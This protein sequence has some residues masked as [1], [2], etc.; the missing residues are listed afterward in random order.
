M[1]PFHYYAEYRVLVCK[2]CQYAVQPA[3]IATHLRSKQHKLPRSQGEEI[4]GKYKNVQLADPRREQVIPTTVVMPIEHLPI[5]RDGLA[6]KHCKFIGRSRD[7]MLRHQR[8]VHGMKIG[9]GRHTDQVEWTTVW[10]Q[11]FFT[12][13]GRCFFQVQNTYRPANSEV[14]P[15]LLQLIHQQLD[16][17]ERKE[18]EKRRI[19]RDSDEATE[20]SPWLERTEWIHHLAGQDKS[21]MAKLV[22]P[23]E[24]EE[25]ELQEVE[26]S[27]V[28]LVKKAQC[29]ISNKQ[30]SI[31][32]LHRLKS[33]HAGQDMERPFEVDMQKKTM[34]RYW[35]VWQ[36][37]LAYVLRTADTESRLYQLTSRQREDIQSVKS[38]VKQLQQEESEEK[39]EELQED[40][41][42]CCLRLCIALLH[43]KLNR[44]YDSAIVS[45]LAVMGLDPIH[46]GELYRFKSPAQYTP[47]LSG[48]IKVAQMLTLQYCY[49]QE[50][51]GEIISCRELFEQLHPQFLTV[52]TSTPMDWVLRLRLYGRKINNRM[53]AQGCINWVGET[54]IYEDIELS[55][56]DFRRLIHKLVEETRDIL[57][58]ELLF[59][60]SMGELP[61]YNWMELRDNA[62][63]DDPEWNF[64]K[65][66][67]NGMLGYERWLLDKILQ[68][69]ELQTRFVHTTG[70]WRQREVNSWFDKIS[71]FLEKLLVLIHMTGRQPA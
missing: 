38:I 3:Y 1:D 54:V 5:Y 48:F 22:Q 9:R 51:D 20:I 69:E 62:A 53:T 6:C 67:K 70:E 26:K 14:R 44:Q 66:G 13:V 65:D 7:W 68:S 8:E 41:D 57:L 2:S 61:V 24:K 16:E 59:V 19:I 63:K 34:E 39:V 17:K 42:I 56:A 10:C 40:L 58:H 45:G 15:T 36:Q 28:R 12:G 60:K 47:L 27:I 33:F 23:A 25:L 18:R 37:L 32:T 30:V 4:V 49:E 29:T 43:H 11:Q 35:K 21:A 52:G 64:I 71:R 31:F 46:G 55:M 50:D